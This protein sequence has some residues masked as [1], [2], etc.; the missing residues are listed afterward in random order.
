[1]GEVALS[2]D[3]RGDKHRRN[4]LQSVGR[5]NSKKTIFFTSFSTRIDARPSDASDASISIGTASQ[6]SVNITTALGQQPSKPM[7]H[8]NYHKSAILSAPMKWTL[9]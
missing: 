4:V 1:M 3:A 9:T 7:I 6:P 2:S 5:T 8:F